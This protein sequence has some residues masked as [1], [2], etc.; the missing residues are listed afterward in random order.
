VTSVERFFESLPTLPVI[1][2]VALRAQQMLDDPDVHLGKLA[3]VLS[4]DPVLAV[5]VSR[6]ANSPLYGA[7]SCTMSLRQAV[8]HLGIPETR[9][10]VVTVALMNALPELPPPMT[11]HVFWRLGLGTALVGRQLA[12]DIKYPR[13]EQAYLAG[14]VH[15]L[16]E[17]T[18]AL[19]RPAEFGRAFRRAA[20]EQRELHAVLLDVFGVRPVDLTAH[21]LERWSFPA[22]ICEAVQFYLDAPDAPEQ[23]LLASMLFASNRMCRGLGLA[24]E[25]NGEGPEDWPSQIAP[26]L[27]ERFAKI[28][29]DDPIDYLLM[30]LQFMTGVEELIANT[31]G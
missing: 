14:L 26:E 9:R 20:A 31:F 22:A 7:R 2:E 23:R 5:R 15:T 11:M 3:D 18:L 24:P 8:Q 12:E 27:W 1:P 10:I 16:G 6:V 13:P 29:Y 30:R 19:N 28:G 17:A 25:E 21:M 4:L